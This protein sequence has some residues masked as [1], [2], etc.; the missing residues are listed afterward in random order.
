MKAGEHVVITR[1]GCIGMLI[2]IFAISK[3]GI[4]IMIDTHQDRLELAKSFG[5][6]H[7]IIVFFKLIS[8]IKFCLSYKF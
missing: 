2:A 7:L 4:P 5:V 8:E 3:G 1:G 6:E